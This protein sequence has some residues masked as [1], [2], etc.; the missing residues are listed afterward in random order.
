MPETFTTKML[1]RGIFVPN[2]TLTTLYT[3]PAATKTVVTSVV[4][5]N[6]DT[7]QHR[8]TLYLS[9][10]DFYFCS[11]LVLLPRETYVMQV[12]G[13]M[14]PGDVLQGSVTESASF[15]HYW[16]SGVEITTTGTP[17]TYTTQR[18]GVVTASTGFPY[19]VSVTAGTK[20]VVTSIVWTSV[21]SATRL[22]TLVSGTGS[23]YIFSDKPLAPIETL[24][25]QANMVLGPAP[26]D[27]LQAGVDAG[28]D[29]RVLAS[30]I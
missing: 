9:P 28:T 23:N 16:M 21:S 10:G 1:A 2:G 7:V 5:C 24:V 25:L 27:S 11:Q 19:L 22:C 17:E 15:V 29:T 6:R 20:V 3:A 4:L 26:G 12:N 13:M 30:G 8:V 18:L 14:A